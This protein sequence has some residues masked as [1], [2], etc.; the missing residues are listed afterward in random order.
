VITFLAPLSGNIESIFLNEKLSVSLFLK[1]FTLQ[2]L[3]GDSTE[4]EPLTPFGD[5]E[6][7]I[8]RLH[9]VQGGT[10][11]LPSLIEEGLPETLL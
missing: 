8:W 6:K 9:K 10:P 11:I 2:S 3:P 7:I 4:G 1:A 5:L